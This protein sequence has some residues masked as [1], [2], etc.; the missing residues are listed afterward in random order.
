[1]ERYTPYDAKVVPDWSGRAGK[2]L[3]EAKERDFVQ[4]RCP[5]EQY[6]SGQTK[7]VSGGASLRVEIPRVPIPTI[8]VIGDEDNAGQGK[9]R[10]LVQ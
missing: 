5:E 4:R 7:F 10:D 9:R 8:L 3:V 6:L 1:M 2:S